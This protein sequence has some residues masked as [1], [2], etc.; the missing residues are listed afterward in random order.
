MKATLIIM[1]LGVIIGLVGTFILVQTH[2]AYS[3]ILIIGGISMEVSAGVALL[4][5]CVRKLSKV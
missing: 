1:I 3:R 5:Q 4:I 2:E